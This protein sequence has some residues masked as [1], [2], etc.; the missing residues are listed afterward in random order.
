MEQ[1]ILSYAISTNAPNES[2]TELFQ[3]TIPTFNS[4]IPIKPDRI[5]AL[6]P[7]R[8]SD[9][10][11]GFFRK[12]LFHRHVEAA[13]SLR[14]RY[15]PVDYLLARQL[16][17]TGISFNRERCADDMTN[18]IQC[19]PFIEELLERHSFQDA[20]SCC[21]AGKTHLKCKKPAHC[22]YVR[23][24]IPVTLKMSSRA[25]QRAGGAHM[26]GFSCA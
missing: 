7:L 23:L 1:P 8:G 3:G 4:D 20:H 5:T 6:R 14:L 16:F 10:A 24:P 2:K 21:Q 15:W 25:F 22:S 12:S 17:N 18:W 26:S 11:P 13:L 9:N 19:N